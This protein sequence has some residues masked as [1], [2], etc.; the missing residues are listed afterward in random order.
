MYGLTKAV[1]ITKPNRLDDF[2]KAPKCVSKDE[3]D[4]IV[5]HTELP[6]LSKDDINIELKGSRLIVSG[7]RKKKTGAETWTGI[8]YTSVKVPNGTK[9]SSVDAS[10]TNGILRI[11]VA[12]PPEV[13]PKKIPIK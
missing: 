6:G 11:E 1:G 10:L 7:E 2:L 12:K 4:K 8:F 5:V 13:L 3:G 9:E